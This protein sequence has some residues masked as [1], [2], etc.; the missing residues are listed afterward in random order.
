MTEEWTSKCFSPHWQQWKKIPSR[1]SRSGRN[2]GGVNE[3][4][5]LKDAGPENE[6]LG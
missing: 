3:T 1:S 5:A 4:V 2:S 6:S